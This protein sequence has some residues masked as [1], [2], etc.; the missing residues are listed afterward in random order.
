[1]N[2][3]SRTP[4]MATLAAQARSGPRCA[5]RAMARAPSRTFMPARGYEGSHEVCEVRAGVRTAVLVRSKLTGRVLKPNRHGR[6]QLRMAGGARVWAPASQL[7]PAPACA[8]GGAL[9]SLGPRKAVCALLLVC[10]AAVMSVITLR[11]GHYRAAGRTRSSSRAQPS[12]LRVGS[13]TFAAALARAVAGIMGG[14]TAGARARS[15]S[16]TR[17]GL[18]ATSLTGMATRAVIGAVLE[19]ATS[20][21]TMRSPVATTLPRPSYIFCAARAAAR[22]CRGR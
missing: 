9:V 1:M 21:A 14:R 15:M 22:P 5:A 20:Q 4:C 11:A 12:L 13:T 19:R 7:I 3:A 16:A 17:S 2:C 6:V 8:A 18:A 10:A